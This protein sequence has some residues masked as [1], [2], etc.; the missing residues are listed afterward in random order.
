MGVPADG[1]MLIETAEERGGGD[2]DE[3]LER[4]VGEMSGEVLILIWILFGVPGVVVEMD[5]GKKLRA[6]G[7]DMSR[8]SRSTSHFLLEKRD[9]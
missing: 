1:S 8:G 5:A 7:D 6:A 4:A 2:R 9:K 3:E